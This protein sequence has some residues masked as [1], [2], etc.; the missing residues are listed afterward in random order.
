MLSGEEYRQELRKAL[1]DDNLAALIQGLPWG[2][3]SGMAITRADGSTRTGYVFCVRIGDWERP[4]YRYVELGDGADATI[5]DDTLACLDHARP[6]DGFE[7]PRVLDDDTYGLA[8]DA[9][10]MARDH[11]LEHWN[12][13]ADK[14]NLEPKVPKVLARAAEIVRTNPPVGVELE[15]IDTSDAG[16]N[17]TWLTA[18]HARPGL[19]DHGG[20]HRVGP[21]PATALSNSC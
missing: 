5:V 1:E 6:L 19:D 7:T 8:F 18:A 10:P 20:I 15:A 4:V 9:W 12:W 13:H 16:P 17:E 14:V 21:Y 3:G 11:I 2:S